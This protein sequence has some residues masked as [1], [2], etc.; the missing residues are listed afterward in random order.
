MT[1]ALTDFQ[2]QT[3]L[4]G[5]N[6]VNSLEKTH[7]M[8]ARAATETGFSP[9]SLNK[10]LLKFA[11]S[12]TAI[13]DQAKL[14]QILTEFNKRAPD[15]SRLANIMAPQDFAKFVDRS[16]EKIKNTPI[17]LNTKEN[18]SFISKSIAKANKDYA[19]TGFGKVAADFY[20]N[21]SSAQ[22]KELRL[23]RKS[24]E[25]GGNIGD[26]KDGMSSGLIAG[27]AAQLGDIVMENAG[28]GELPGKMMTLFTA[29]NKLREANKNDKNQS[30]NERNASLLANSRKT[31][32]SY[33]E[34]KRVTTDSKEIL[35]EAS[36]Q[37]D[38]LTSS[39]LDAFKDA[40]S[41]TDL[42]PK[43][44]DEY[45]KDLISGKLTEGQ[46][47]TITA[48]WKSALGSDITPEDKKEMKEFRGNI[49]SDITSLNEMNKSIED[50]TH[51]YNQ[52]AKKELD[53]LVVATKA[54]ADVDKMIF[55]ELKGQFD[56]IDKELKSGALRK[57]PSNELDALREQLQTD[58]T[59]SVSKKYGVNVSESKGMYNDHTNRVNENLSDLG[60][61]ASAE[62][63]EALEYNGKFADK[64]TSLSRIFTQPTLERPRVPELKS[65]VSKS[66][67]K[68]PKP[69]ASTGSTVYTEP[70]VLAFAGVP[71]VA[72]SA[73]VVPSA[74]VATPPDKKSSDAEI[75]K[76][77][78]ALSSVRSSEKN[79]EE[80]IKLLE[81]IFGQNAEKAV[82][83]Q[84]VNWPAS[85]PSQ[86][87]AS[88][89]A[90][91]VPMLS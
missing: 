80:T 2:Y 68:T 54:R 17:K 88:S 62:L 32:A 6:M 35:V 20:K 73:L 52:E 28:F 14:T 1:K 48:S 57:T 67:R 84:I 77:Q 45:Q 4:N 7:K 19:S 31:E 23:M 43:R 42:S 61:E 13:G 72:E 46:L 36:L 25:T 49:L 27:T 63:K 91:S 70:D 5:S 75:D 83:V 90:P 85:S 69:M 24:I 51:A 33:G 50:A 58:I 56:R 65:T 71:S 79:S 82:K 3:K 78:D 41:K 18:I 64:L 15:Y 86:P 9:E 66:T 30:A 29:I 81:K 22:L 60:I 87:K 37:K 12:T 40:L 44:K 47:K 76:R 53:A 55:D 11:K 89:E 10:L 38:E 16:L 39:L 34:Q 59:N 21:A 8:L 26:N 74:R